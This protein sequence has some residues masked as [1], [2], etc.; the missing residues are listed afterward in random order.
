MG[1]K[2]HPFY[3]T[4]APTR[5]SHLE[6]FGTWLSQYE[7]PRVRALD[8]GTGSGVLALMLARAG[9]GDIVAT[10]SNP[11]AIE[12]VSRELRRMTVKPP[13]ELIHGD[14]LGP[15]NSEEE[16]VVFNPPWI[17][18]SVTSQLDSALYF[19]PS[20]FERFFDQAVARLA[21]EGRIALV[22]SNVMSLLQP[23][24]PHPIEAELARGRLQLV[25][26]RGRKVK[27]TP[28]KSGRRRRTKE[29]VEV[30]ELAHA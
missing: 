12:S 3:G 8:V 29:R 5:V 21:K 18:G 28:D 10:D 17:Q 25:S 4:Y 15:G 13:I 14:L 11:N 27:P 20:L 9:F 30:W 7:G 2:L 24:V 23:D 19:E 26:K 6:L 16:L 22:F 1:H